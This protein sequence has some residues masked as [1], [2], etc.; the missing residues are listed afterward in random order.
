[1]FDLINKLSCQAIRFLGPSDR[2]RGRIS[3]YSSGTCLVVSF[4]DIKEIPL[5]TLEK[6]YTG[7]IYFQV[8]LKGFQ[9]G[10]VDVMSYLLGYSP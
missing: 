7:L 1:M 5:M 8:E 6:F 10:L 2:L 9:V 3:R 4:D